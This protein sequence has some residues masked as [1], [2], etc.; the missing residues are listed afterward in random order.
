MK[1]CPFCAE[2]IQDEAI[3]CKHCGS[4]FKNKVVR[5]IEKES[6][7]NKKIWQKM[8][9]GK[10][11]LLKVFR[12]CCFILC[13]LIIV[14]LCIPEA[15]QPSYTGNTDMLVVGNKVSGGEVVT[16]Y[17]EGGTEVPLLTNKKVFEHLDL[18]TKT[19]EAGSDFFVRSML[20]KGL[21]I[22]VPNGTKAILFTKGAYQG[23]PKVMVVEGKHDE[24]VGYVSPK[25]IVK[26]KEKKY[27]D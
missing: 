2:E 21:L 16:L 12:T 4:T 7:A 19:I 1:K 8:W 13:G 11:V 3:K 22:L 24:R 10:P 15:K 25:T 20:E 26:A 17:L 27:E 5:F 6:L 14:I 9:E 18:I 23:A